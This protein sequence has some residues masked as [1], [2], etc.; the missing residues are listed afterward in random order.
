MPFLFAYVYRLWM[1][2]MGSPLEV[3]ILRL[4]SRIDFVGFLGLVGLLL[5]GLIHGKGSV[6]GCAVGGGRLVDKMLYMN[7]PVSK[8][9]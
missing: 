2:S 7:D 1:V 5:L 9:K 3:F 4:A 6:L 8:K